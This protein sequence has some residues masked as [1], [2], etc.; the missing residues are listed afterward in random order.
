MAHIHAVVL[1]ERSVVVDTISTSSPSSTPM[2]A[3][4]WHPV[5]RRTTTDSA[6][7][8]SLVARL[9]ERDEIR[10]LNIYRLAN[11]CKASRVARTAHRRAVC[12][13]RRSLGTNR[14]GTAAAVA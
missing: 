8:T 6:M 4:A 1:Q 12:N 2:T 9:L 14:K 10:N 3:S 11:D 7:L 13:I 5:I